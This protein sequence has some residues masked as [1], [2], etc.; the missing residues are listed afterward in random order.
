MDNDTKTHCTNCGKEI[1]SK[2]DFCPFCG[3]KQ[4]SSAS[5]DQAKDV[6]NAED[7]IEGSPKKPK[8]KW[9]KRWWVWIVIVIL[10][11][12]VIG[13]L[14]SSDDSDS[15]SSS[16]ESS[17]TSTAKKNSSSSSSSSASTSVRKSV[18]VLDSNSEDQLA[19]KGETNANQIRYG[20]LIKSNDY[21]GKPYS[22]SKGEVLQASE[23]KGVTTLLVYIDDDTDQLFEVAVR[24]KTKAIEDDY[25]SI[26]GVLDKM[27]DY[28]T[29]SGGSN[30][31]PV[32]FAKKATVVGHDDN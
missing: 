4:A 14:G 29:Q 15:S 11:I 1:P 3:A 25:V 28:D 9:Y 8:K 24:G 22:I 21:Y 12:G 32:I 16:D 27:T 6:E 23:S 2:V 17:A 26:N 19:E 20:E 10:A 18:Q 13:A 30:T 5:S 7:K 31:V